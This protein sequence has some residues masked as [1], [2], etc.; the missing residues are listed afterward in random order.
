M[1]VPTVAPPAPPLSAL[2][3]RIRLLAVAIALVLAVWGSAAGDDDAF[4]FGPFRMYASTQSLDAPTTWLE[5]QTVA[6]DG[7]RHAVP[8]GAVGVRRAELEGQV[9]SFVANPRALAPLLAAYQAGHPD[10]GAVGI[11]VVR[12]RQE[13]AGGRPQGPISTAVVV[14]WPPP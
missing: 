4:P 5:L 8:D 7:S 1:P 11:S 2:A 9:G 12:H 3:R 6:A 10:A 14:T 13:M